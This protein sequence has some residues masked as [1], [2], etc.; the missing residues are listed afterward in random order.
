MVLVPEVVD[1]VG[2]RVPVLA[3]GGIGSGRQIAAAFALGA[4][5]AWLGSCWLTSAE[6]EMSTEAT[7][8]AL[9]KAGSSDTVRSK[10]Y[11]GKPARLLKNRWTR[12]WEEPDAPQP[13]PMPL[14][15]LLVSQAHQR[16]IRAG[17]PDVVPIPVGQIV[18]RMNS[19][20]PVA[21]IMQ[22]LVAEFRATVTRLSSLHD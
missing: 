8:T 16:L 2:A 3:A 5:G 4:H 10:I 1:A 18:G 22:D 9:L 7:R 12:A 6:Y 11:T 13:L 15:N 21:E 14:Q 19:V 20:R 17:D